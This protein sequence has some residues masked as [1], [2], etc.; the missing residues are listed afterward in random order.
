MARFD[1]LHESDVA[2]L[3]KI[4]GEASELPATRLSA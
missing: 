4:A 2:A 1:L 3:L